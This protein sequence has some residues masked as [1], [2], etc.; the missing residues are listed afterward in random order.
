MTS[1]HCYSYRYHFWKA[2]I[3]FQGFVELTYSR[4]NIETKSIP[5]QARKWIEELFC[6][7]QVLWQHFMFLSFCI[8]LTFILRA[9]PVI[10]VSCSFDLQSIMSLHFLPYSSH[11]HLCPFILHSCPLIFFLEL[12]KRL[13]GLAR[14]RNATNGDR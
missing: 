11:V 3:A 5:K 9:F 7:F 1:C 6:W 10:F 8:D 14:G 2:P 13:Y 12:W 4:S